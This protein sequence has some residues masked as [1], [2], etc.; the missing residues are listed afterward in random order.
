V[1]ELVAL[2]NEAKAEIETLREIVAVVGEVALRLE[3]D[4]PAAQTYTR[5]L[6]VM[7]DRRAR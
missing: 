3:P 2:I 7:E 4:G 1:S 6:K 5:Y